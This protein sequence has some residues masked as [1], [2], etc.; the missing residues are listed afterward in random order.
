LKDHKASKVPKAY[1][2]LKDH[3][4]SKVPKAYRG[5]KVLVM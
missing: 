5:L 4:A 3:K 2:G 1:R